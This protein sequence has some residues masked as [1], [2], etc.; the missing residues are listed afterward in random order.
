LQAGAQLISAR[1]KTYWR[2]LV[3][4]LAAALVITGVPTPADAHARGR[5]RHD[6]VERGIISK[7]NSI[8]RANGLPRVRANRALARSA[9]YHSADM[10]RMNFFA[11][12]SSNGQSFAQRVEHFRPSNRVGETLAYVPT[13]D[14]RRSAARIVEL[15]MNSPPHRAS[16]LNRSFRRIGVARRKGALGSLRVVVFTADFASA[17]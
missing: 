5:S 17:H 12:S 6:K 14:P 8:R 9:D 13:A 15:W 4:C 2:A 1:L 11:H 3:T 7:I 16:L 10:L